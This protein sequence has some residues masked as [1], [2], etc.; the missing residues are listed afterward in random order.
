M[1]DGEAVG[2]GDGPDEGLGRWL[3]MDG[4]WGGA[5][6]RAT[7]VGDAVAV[8]VVGGSGMAAPGSDGVAELLRCPGGVGLPQG[9]HHASQDGG[10]ETGAVGDA[11]A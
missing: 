3:G 4:E 1:L 8:V 5:V 2:G 10:G 11:E 9:G 7:H 6:G